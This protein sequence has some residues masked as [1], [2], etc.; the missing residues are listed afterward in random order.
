MSAAPL[1]A[2]DHVLL[3]DGSALIFRAYFA[4]PSLTRRG[5]RAPIG[6]VSGFCSMLWRLLRVTLAQE[7][8]SHVGVIFDRPVRNFRHDIY[9]SYK[10]NRKAQPDD[11]KAQQRPIRHAVQAFNL[12]EYDQA[13]VEA[14]DVIAT[15]ARIAGDAGAAC[16]IVSS[17]KDLVQLVRD[18]VTIYDAMKDCRIDRA[19]AREKF[20][21]DPEMLADVQ[22]LSGDMVDNVPGVP[23]V[24][25][26][27]AAQLVSEFG[28]VRSVIAAAHDGRVKKEK[29]RTLLIEH[30]DAALLSK[31]LVT[32]DDCVL[33]DCSIDE[34]AVQEFEPDKLAAFLNEM[35]LTALSRRVLRQES[36]MVRQ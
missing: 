28:D 24:G 25:P 8:I 7:R 18:R 20:G 5:D 30:A 12:R 2:D 4:N 33:L 27:T 36:E 9:P 26:V 1:T 15:I 6:A 19:A 31:E 3:I 22:A 13:M 23:K 35:D 16:T 29:L 14:D 34:F 10:A 21:V 11:L 17:D 32:L